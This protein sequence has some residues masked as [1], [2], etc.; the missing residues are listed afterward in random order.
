MTK[1]KSFSRKEMY[2][3]LQ[4][5]MW[6]NHYNGDMMKSCH[7]HLAYQEFLKNAEEHCGD[8][9]QVPA[10]CMRCKLQFIEVEAQNALD[11]IWGD[12]KGHCGKKCITECE[13][14]P[15]KDKNE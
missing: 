1:T 7:Q 10:T 11:V 12:P 2:D 4:Y 14:V 3:F 6:C 15:E 9:T 13:G 5:L 8:C